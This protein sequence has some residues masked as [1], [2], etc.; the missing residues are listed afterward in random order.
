[1]KH[2]R[3][4]TLLEVLLATMLLASA[5]TVTAASVRGMSRAQARSEAMLQQASE[6]NAVA[7]LLRA[8][9][10]AAM[11]VKFDSG[12][13]REVMFV[14]DPTRLEFIT[15]MP[16]Y[17]TLSGPMRQVIEIQP[18]AHGRLI[19]ITQARRDQRGLRCEAGEMTTMIDGLSRAEFRYRG[20]EEDGRPGPW[21][22][23]WERNERLPEWVQVQLIA[24]T[25]EPAW[26]VIDIRLPLATNPVP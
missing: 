26:P 11:A 23:Q 10:S 8:R 12:D 13:G 14:G 17:P 19:C 9:L 15:E 1:M 2:A 18:S 20:R 3:G 4:F 5:I 24:G 16:P 6:R 21:L 25:V 22:P 7:G